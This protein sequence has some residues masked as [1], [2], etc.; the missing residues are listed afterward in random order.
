MPGRRDCVG[1]CCSFLASRGRPPVGAPLPRLRTQFHP[2]LLNWEHHA[3]RLAPSALAPPAV[4]R[5]PGHLGRGA[6]LPTEPSAGG[7]SAHG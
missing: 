4:Q 5:V 6:V 1:G 3:S 2:W 7:R